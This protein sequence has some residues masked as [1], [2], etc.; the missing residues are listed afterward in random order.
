MK[1]VAKGRDEVLK[2]LE[3]DARK[4][5]GG[6]DG[7]YM[8]A[9]DDYGT[10]FAVIAGRTFIGTGAVMIGDKRLSLSNGLRMEIK[11]ARV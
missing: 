7:E 2:Y 3:E 8:L 5:T 11:D 6:K 4:H 10:L 1:V 9:T